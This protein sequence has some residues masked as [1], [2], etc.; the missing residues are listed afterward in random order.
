[1]DSWVG[2]AWTPLLDSQGSSASVPGAT[3]N[4]KNNSKKFSPDD[5][6]LTPVSQSALVSNRRW[7]V[8]GVNYFRVH[9]QASESVIFV[10]MEIC[11]EL[12]ELFSNFLHI[13]QKAI[14]LFA[15]A[16]WMD[17]N[18]SNFSCAFPQGESPA[19]IN[20][21]SPKNLTSAI[22]DPSI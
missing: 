10:I 15:P 2:R 20:P 1:M 22:H 11:V 12:A 19:C 4:M 17:R 8:L 21:P 5:I 13:I 7:F 9:L 6:I 18:L 16:G 14:A 3:P